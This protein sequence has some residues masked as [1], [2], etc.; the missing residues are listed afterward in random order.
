MCSRIVAQMQR[1]FPVICF[2]TIIAGIILSKSAS[3]GM[4]G[5]SDR[6]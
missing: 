3:K 2:D 4:D 5:G 1:E 6:L